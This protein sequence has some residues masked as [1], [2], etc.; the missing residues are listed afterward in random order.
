MLNRA[1]PIALARPR[2]TLLVLGGLSALGFPPFHLW[3]LALLALG[4]AAV[5]IRFSPTVRGAFLRGWLFALA[6]F[7]G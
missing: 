7:T 5:L 4:A 1:L 2:L 3:P 6:H